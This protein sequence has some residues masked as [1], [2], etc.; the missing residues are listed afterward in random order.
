VDLSGT[1]RAAAADEGLR[2]AFSD[3]GFDDATWTLV[4]VPGHWRSH[5][6]FAAH[7]GPLLYR[8]PFRAPP[9]GEGRRSW[10]TFEG[11]FYQGDVWL[12]G[13]YLGDTEG[14]FFPHTFEVTDALRAGGRDHM[15]AVEVACGRPADLRPKPKH[16]LMGVFQDGY[17]LDP[18][19]NPGGLWR[20]VRLHE[21]GPVR[22]AALRVLCSE[23][24]DERAL[25]NV[26]VVLDAS[27]PMAAMIRV[28]V[29]ADGDGESTAPP[30]SST[31]RQRLAQ[32]RNH[33]RLPIAVERP[34][35]WWPRALGEQPLYDVEV[36]V[37]LPATEAGNAAAAT[38]PPDDALFTTT[39]DT[40]V[41]R[42]GLREIRMKAWVV[43]VNGERLFLKGSNQGP[44]RL[45]LGEASPEEL[46]R[47]A[48]LAVEA[49]LDLIRLYGHISRPELYRAADRLGLLLWQDLPL[50]GQYARGVR[51]Q[52]I[53]QA[54]EAVDLLGH[55]PSVALWCGHAGHTGSD[56]HSSTALPSWNKS[57]LA[58]SLR[59]VLVR[60]DPTRP[61][62]TYSGAFPGPV[63]GGG[64]AHLWCGW[65]RG[66]ERDFPG[67]LRVV[68][69][70]ARFVS[71]FGAQAV[72]ATDGWMQPER[73][74]DLDW[75]TLE[76]RHALAGA[77]FER[78][79][80]PGR[81]SDFADWRDA[82]QDYQATVLRFHVETLRRLKYRPTG[83]FCQFSFAD[84]GPAVSWSVLDHERAPKK[85]H[86]AL[87]AACAPVIVVADRPAA[88]YRPGETLA[89]D[90]HVVSDLRS[91]IEE[92][93]VT[94][95]LSWSGG[96]TRRAWAGGVP[97]DSC[98]LVGRLE[99]TVPPAPG[100]L[101][102]GLEIEGRGATGVVKAASA[103][104]ARIE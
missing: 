56:G 51:R 18:E 87:A 19:W 39:S 83:G 41:R 21:T 47:D 98:V 95:T 71:E 100:L 33:M 24:N 30:A 42:T 8:R 11:I 78:Y 94:A 37:L 36:E 92:A 49:G 59:R 44:T 55:H 57:V 96:G 64:D 63:S 53:R 74:P 29:T 90:V 40:A 35:L 16:S 67:I 101:S 32:G 43:S 22:V 70:V 81:F 62:V 82:T 34:R 12:D 15:L 65:H 72:P 61:V 38:W 46:E 85:A 80:P 20:P 88:V 2:R 3:T 86:A 27:A 77:A 68:P 91:S 45:A 14:Y 97:A 50:S 60:A 54:R 13:S 66:T 48:E 84:S 9:P 23:A 31:T 99:L 79:V 28:S 75:P 73:W 102:I 89:L 58:G 10:L 6:S 104:Q 52:A 5:P 103:Y 17:G 69:R 4:Q 26:G 1:W 93:M 25:L 7:D 76:R